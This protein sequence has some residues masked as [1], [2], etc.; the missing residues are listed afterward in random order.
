[1]AL[2]EEKL[3]D[4]KHYYYASWGDWGNNARIKFHDNPSSG[5]SD[6]SDWTKGIG[7]P[8]NTAIPPK[9]TTKHLLLCGE[10]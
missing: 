9:H 8:T 3:L 6:N 2:Q 7:Q 10:F 4:N 5:C 1:M